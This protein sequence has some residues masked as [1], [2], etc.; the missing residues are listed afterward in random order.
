MLKEE[1]VKLTTAIKSLKFDITK[2]AQDAKILQ[3]GM[4]K[5]E[6]ERDQ[7]LKDAAPHKAQQREIE[8]KKLVLEEKKLAIAGKKIDAEKVKRKAAVETK[9]LDLKKIEAQKNAEIA[10]EKA[11]KEHAIDIVHARVNAKE[12]AEIRKA[13]RKMEA[14]TNRMHEKNTNITINLFR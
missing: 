5:V 1:K 6:S 12:R 9:K 3:K 8:L 4:K 14:T 13:E 7:L 2:L 10:T 11:K